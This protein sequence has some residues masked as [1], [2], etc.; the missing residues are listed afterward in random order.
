MRGILF[1]PIHIPGLRHSKPRKPLSLRST[2]ILT[3]LSA[4][5]VFLLLGGIYVTTYAVTFIWTISADPTPKSVEELPL[6]TIPVCMLSP[7]FLFVA[8]AWRF[9]LV[10]RLARFVREKEKRD[11]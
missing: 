2:I 9:R 3:T 1:K 11:A 6:W 10:E 5:S 7:V 4:G 8:V